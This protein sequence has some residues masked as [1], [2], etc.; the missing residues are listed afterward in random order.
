MKFQHLLSVALCTA[1]LV[2][3]SSDTLG[4]TFGQIRM[5]N[6][7]AIH[8][9][10]LKNH[11]VTRVLDSYSIPYERNDA[12]VVVRLKIDNQWNTVDGIDIIP[13][14]TPDTPQPRIM[15]HDIF[16][17]TDRGI[18]HLVSELTVR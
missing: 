13:M 11:F 7:R 12:G 4:L 18:F 16:F 3:A 2:A 17:S 9:T 6:K 5:L 10:Q 1:C 15:A 8:V 14:M